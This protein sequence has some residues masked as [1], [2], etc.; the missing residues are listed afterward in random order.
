M[1]GTTAAVIPG[2]IDATHRRSSPLLCTHRRNRTGWQNHRSA[3]RGQGTL[4][5]YGCGLAVCRRFAGCVFGCRAK[6]KIVDGWCGFGEFKGMAARSGGAIAVTCR[7]GGKCRK[8]AS[9]GDA[10]AALGAEQIRTRNT[11]HPHPLE[12]GLDSK[13]KHKST[14]LILDMA[15]ILPSRQAGAGLRRP[16]RR[17]LRGAERMTAPSG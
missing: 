14:A 4:G 15:T 5:G 3:P 17:R 13:I 1:I 7:D 8:P 2:T 10:V 6:A 9:C 16:P 11:H 12:G